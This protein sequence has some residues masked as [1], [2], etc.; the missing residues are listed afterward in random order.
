MKK[1]G[2]IYETT[3]S[4]RGIRYCIDWEALSKE[5]DAFHLTED[6]MLQMRLEV[7]GY[8]KFVDFYH[9]DVETYLLFNL[10]CIDEGSMNYID[11]NYER[12]A[13]EDDD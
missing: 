6:A 1:L 13:K 9:W 11:L 12:E 7:P 8:R 5:Y 2:F 10:D 4:L 3:D